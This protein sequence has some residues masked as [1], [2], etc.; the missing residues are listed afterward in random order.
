ML[1]RSQRTYPDT[2]I[3]ITFV[4][5][6]NKRSQITLTANATIQQL[7][8]ATY[9]RRPEKYKDASLE[10]YLRAINLSCQGIKLKSFASTLVASNI[11]TGS[12]IRESFKKWITAINVDKNTLEITDPITLEPILGKPYF[13]P[14]CNHALGKESLKQW[15]E[16]RLRQRQQP[17]C[18]CCRAVITNEHIDKLVPVRPEP[19]PAPVAVKLIIIET[20]AGMFILPFPGLGLPMLFNF[21]PLPMPA[22]L[23]PVQNEPHSAPSTPATPRIEDFPD[24]REDESSELLMPPTPPILF[25]RAADEERS[26]SAQSTPPFAFFSHSSEDES[27][28]EPAPAIEPQHP[29][30]QKRKRDEDNDAPGPGR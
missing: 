13:L 20:P 28:E 1:L 22:D 3:T 18:P 5:S 25:P 6:E 4:S 26:R 2:E 7:Y 10:N 12:I 15:I 14:D 30:E 27:D 24:D 9:D 19:D 16:T 17:N 8:Q 11:A 23:A 29:R 21:D